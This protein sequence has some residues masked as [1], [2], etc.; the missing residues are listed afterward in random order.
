VSGV[1]PVIPSYTLTTTH[2]S[3]EWMQYLAVVIAYLRLFRAIVIDQ[4]Y[5]ELLRRKDEICKMTNV[6]PKE[7][8]ASLQV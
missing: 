6:K 3:E 8:E 2:A 7:F 4:R 1:Q 5:D